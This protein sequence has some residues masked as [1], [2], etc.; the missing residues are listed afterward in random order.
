M[1]WSAVNYGAAVGV[2]KQFSCINTIQLRAARHYLGV[3][4]Y[5]PNSAVQGDSGWKPTAVRQRSAV[6]NQWQRL[7]LIDNNRIN[8]KIFEC[9]T[10]NF[11]INRMLRDAGVIIN[12]VLNYR[13]IKGKGSETVKLTK[14]KVFPKPNSLV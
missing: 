5:T 6:L 9:K 12:E 3:G 8:Y 11:R 2:T 4:K 14:M 7:K 10:W 13:V 1:V